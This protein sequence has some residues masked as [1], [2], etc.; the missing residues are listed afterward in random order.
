MRSCLL[1]RNNSSKQRRERNSR[2]TEWSSTELTID[3][4]RSP[5]NSEEMKSPLQQCSTPKQ[6]HPYP[7][8]TP[9]FPLRVLHFRRHLGIAGP[10]DFRSLLLHLMC[11]Y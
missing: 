10:S 7:P 2:M 8:H 3:S 4:N 9:S 5:R 11:C 6:S 1:S